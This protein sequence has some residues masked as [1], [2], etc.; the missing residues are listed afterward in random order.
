[1]CCFHACLTLRNWLFGLYIQEYEQYGKDRAEYGEE[2]IKKLSFHLCEAKVPAVSQRNLASYRKFYQ[3][4]PEILHT[5]S[6][7]LENLKFDKN[8]DITILQTLYAKLANQTLPKLQANIPKIPGD[9]LVYSLSFSHYIELLQITEPIK[10][11][12][13]EVEC[14]GNHWAVRE[15]RRQI[16]SLYY[17]RCGLSK[18][19]EKLAQLANKKIIT[20]DADS[21]I[22]DPYI[23]EFLGL[24]AEQVMDENHLSHA[25]INKLQQFLLEL[26][27]G[28]CFEA[29]QKRILIGDEYFFIDMVFYHRI[30]KSNVLIELKI[31]SFNHNHIGQLNTYLNYYKKNEMHPGDNPPIGILLCTKK[32]H[33]L[34][35]YATSN[36]SNKLFVS[37]YKLE[38]PS[39]N[40]VKQFIE[41]QLSKN[42][43]Q[44][45]QENNI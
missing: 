19:K 7:K 1:M 42:L 12:F 8:Q 26:G 29:R 17:E 43:S 23:F 4:Y 10:R 44:L 21:V 33:A 34:V 32:N 31:D 27:K 45:I 5:A 38:L 40:E 37:N 11:R 24:R 30:L 35:E 3:Y 22:K 14:I 18:N 9:V 15:L 6:T 41:K 13:Y 16:G 2:T 28:F 36:S 20:S 39:E 25:L